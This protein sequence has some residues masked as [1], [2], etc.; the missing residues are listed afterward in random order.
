MMRTMS[1]SP[2][3]WVT[4][5]PPGQ[6]A[7]GRETEQSSS[8]HFCSRVKCQLEFVT[9]DLKHLQ[10]R[11]GC[12]WNGAHHVEEV[13]GHTFPSPKR[14]VLPICSPAWLCHFNKQ[15][16]CSLVKETPFLQKK[17]PL[18]SDPLNSKQTN[19]SSAPAAPWWVKICW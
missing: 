13:R 15:K 1:K 19:R 2:P 9:R 14:R 17:G 11:S 5:S 18:H 6:A 16:Y 4:A 8:W 10:E 7:F 3:Q 12:I